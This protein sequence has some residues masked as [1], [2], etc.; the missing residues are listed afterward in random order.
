MQGQGSNSYLRELGIK[1][2]TQLL[3]FAVQEATRSTPP[4]PR[5]WGQPAP[6]VG[7]PGMTPAFQ[8]YSG[9]PWCALAGQLAT[10]KVYLERASEVVDQRL[11]RFYLEKSRGEFATLKSQLAVTTGDI[12]AVT[13]AINNLQLRLF[14]LADP[15]GAPLPSMLNAVVAEVE[16]LITMCFANAE[17]PQPMVHPALLP[18][19]MPANPQPVQGGVNGHDESTTNGPPASGGQPDVD[20]QGYST[21]NPYTDFIATGRYTPSDHDGS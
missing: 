15:R 19:P 1:L 6:A 17:R 18:Q 20:A 14:H 13:G 10:A 2:G 3:Q 5:P 16:D 11:I 4:A 8:P 9:C 7:Q 21:R 12:E